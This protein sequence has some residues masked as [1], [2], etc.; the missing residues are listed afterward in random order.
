MTKM[1]GQKLW[2]AMMDTKADNTA[3]DCE[4]NRPKR[5]VWKFLQAF[6]LLKRDV[7]Y[8]IWNGHGKENTV[9]TLPKGTKVRVVMSSRFGS[10]GICDDLNAIQGYGA[11]LDPEDLEVLE[12]FEV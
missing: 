8:R 5:D 3:W 7:T 6:A 12:T 1:T 10:V 2:E 4:N 11:R 9:Y